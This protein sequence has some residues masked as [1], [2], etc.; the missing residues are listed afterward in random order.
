MG[1][2]VSI[3]QLRAS[4][5]TVVDR[6]VAGDVTTVTRDGEPVAAI[7]PVH[8]LDAFEEWEDRRLAERA[9]EAEREPGERLSLT[10]VLDEPRRS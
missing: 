1:E 4:V 9:T 10:E 5:A 2:T 3:R 7:I 8:M 6:A